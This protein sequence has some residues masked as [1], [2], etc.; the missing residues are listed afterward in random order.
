MTAF[1][2][3]FFATPAATA[4]FSDDATIRAM[5]RFEAALARAE[6]AAGVIPAAA[7]ETIARI[8]DAFAPPEGAA[9]ATLFADAAKAGTLAIPLVKLL[10]AAVKAEDAAAAAFVHFGG[11][12]QDVVDTAL[13]LQLATALD[14]IAADLTRLTAAARTLCLAHR[15]TLMLGRTLLQPALPMSFGLKAA[16]WLLAVRES[17]QRLDRLTPEVLVPQFGGAAGTLASLG[18]AGL[19]VAKDL[20]AHLPGLHRPATPLPWHTRRGGLAALCAE[21]AVLT[22]AVGKIARDVSLMMQ[23]EVAEAFEPVEAGRGGSSA[24]PHKRNPVRCMQML[25]AAD[26]APHL[27]AQLI[28]TLPQEH[29]R[30]L[31]GWQAEW[32]AVPEL[33]KLTAGAVANG[34]ALLEGLRIDPDRMRRNLDALKG[35]PYAEAAATALIPHLGREAAHK[36]VEAASRTVAA[37]GETLAAALAADPTV[38]THLDAAAL[39]ALCDPKATLGATQAFIAAVLAL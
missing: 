19:A 5:C 13:M 38:A 21:L 28:A 16:Q 10:T 8:V 6:G 23:F 35:L 12:S 32:A 20:P 22:G 39:A 27:A 11:T 7:A 14:S 30:A 2:D 1:S 18:Q 3:A 33:V 37:T 34:A 31:G 36:A 25:A 24:M 29:E 17:R 15:E 4:A 9:R 26:R